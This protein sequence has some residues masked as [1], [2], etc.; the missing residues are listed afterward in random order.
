MAEENTE[1]LPYAQF[2]KQTFDQ[3][4]SV[5]G[6]DTGMFAKYLADTLGEEFDQPDMLTYDGLREGTAPI[7]NL[8][9]EGYQNLPP[10]K[11]KL[12]NDQII[13]LF[14][15]DMEGNPIKAGTFL[16]GVQ[17]E[18]IPTA[19]SIPT[20][21]GGYKAGSALVSMVPPT[22]PWT[23]G[24][25]FGVPLAFGTLASIGG[26]FMG[27]KIADE[28]MGEEPPM[29]PGQ[30]AA[31]EAGKTATS[32][33]G[34][35]T[36]P[37]AIPKQLNF[38]VE[39]A[40]QA[41]IKG[42]GDV[43]GPFETTGGLKAA[44]FLEG[45]VGKLGETAKA[46]PVPFLTIEALSGAGQT[47]GAY[48][49]ESGAPGQAIPRLTYETL[50][51][52]SV[53]VA[54]DLLTRKFVLAA[55]SIKG[56]YKAA[57]EGK[58]TEAFGYLK[59]ERKRQVINYV[60]DVIEEAGEDPNVII[61]RLGSNEFSDILVDDAGNPIELTA[62]LKSGSP[63]LLALEKSLEGVTSGVGRE[64]S[65]ANVSATRALR[66]TINALFALQNKE[67]TQAASE[68]AQAT[69]SA[70]MEKELG[71]AWGKVF[72]AF[73]AIGAPTARQAQL[74][75]NLES[76]LSN[77]LEAAR[78]NEKRLWKSVDTSFSI[79][80]F[81]DEEGQIT[82]TPQFISWMENNLPETEE[83]LDDMYPNIA[84]LIK[85]VNRKKREL[86][87][88][89]SDG[90]DGSAPTL[91]KELKKAY[92]QYQKYEDMFRGSDEERIL[93]SVSSRVD[94]IEDVNDKLSYLRQQAASLRERAKN[95]E[96]DDNN[97]IRKLATAYDRLA[98]LELIK[99]R[100]PQAALTQQVDL[101]D[102]SATEIYDMYSV[103]LA[104]GKEL[105][106][107]GKVNSSRLAYGFAQALMRDLDNFD[108]NDA[109]Y[110]IAR[111]YSRAL[112]D[113][114]TRSFVGD[115]LQETKTGAL[116]VAPEMIANDIFT[117]DAGYLRMKQLD[118]VGQFELTQALTNLSESAGTPDLRR[119][120]DR[121]I[122]YSVNEDT[123][124]VDTARLNKWLKNNRKGLSKYPG[125]LQNV[126]R[127]VETTTTI[128]GTTENILRNI[129]AQA[130]DPKTGEV[131]VAALRKWM[132]R[133]ENQDILSAMPA[134][135]ADLE[136][137]ESARILLDDQL[138]AQREDLK[139]LKAQV[140]FM[141]LLPGTTENPATAAAKALANQQKKPV[142]S[143]DNLLDV[144]KKAP[145]EW[146]TPD[147]VTHTKEDALKGLRA[148]FIEA[149]MVKSGGTS[150]TFSA[151][152][153][154][155]TI[156]APHRNSENKVSL[157][158]W[159][160]KNEVM[161]KVEMDRLRSL[162]TEL[163]KMESFVASG[164]VGL[165]E[166]S[167]TVGPMMD[168]YLRIVG[169]SVGSR[170]QRMIPGD[171]GAGQL[172]A[173]GAGSKAF[174]SAYSK[175]FADMPESMKMDVMTE[176]FKDP[177][178]LATMLSK[179]RS[180]RE[181]G[182]ISSR[183]IKLLTEKGLTKVT[184]GLSNVA[185]RSLPP[186]VRETE[187]VIVDQTPPIIEE[188][189]ANLMPQTV[190]PTNRTEVQPNRVTAPAPIVPTQNNASQPAA[191]SRYAALFPND[192]I[193][194]MIQPQQQGI[195]SL[196]G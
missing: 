121:A 102:L 133:P 154:F 135:K 7:F 68:I 51:G 132:A 53:P 104:K 130:F 172:V 29:L 13:E 90:G 11:R 17:R 176:M 111:S 188:E 34:W 153:F 180:E 98:N 63:A 194:G 26:Y 38:G 189:E 155:D 175:I 120:L 167:E 32:A 112:N 86:G 113:A 150:Q 39:A 173:A 142:A 192:P 137:V 82:D 20:F 28:I 127:A 146:T 18:V 139:D 119:T 148:S 122:N 61:Q 185:R 41:L 181:I 191:R 152:E 168:F 141:D 107:Q 156:F 52:I 114:F 101:K 84:P 117:A 19:T 164:D 160:L 47:G 22:T 126:E 163:V 166:L 187:E 190:L 45:T 162:A 96:F 92:D 123:G 128:R 89:P 93:E 4:M 157:S 37:F 83:A 193:S 183:L 125:V 159:M 2:D 36:L 43:A 158:D 73:E 31:Y 131:N 174:R 55:K 106:A 99:S 115:I 170:F 75:Q 195:G 143:W 80:S 24:I 74:G 35:L 116:K 65:S 14:S 95:K 49:A 118:Q 71:N 124:L 109:S 136:N 145:D 15:V 30:Q 21:M 54:A 94:N 100:E 87:L 91:S 177:D 67:S 1:N 50:G 23:A 178:L 81:I 40:K 5:Y 108:T 184:T 186:V 42:R 182:N 179:G 57:R 27:E 60:L 149:A 66:N 56:G 151:R 6:N 72:S 140:S 64:R 76:I 69:F 8:L 46:A 169:S 196:F 88:T 58:I 105:K 138:S 77:R 78:T 134:L 10:A 147:G 3:L 97:Q 9:G 12:S 103:A 165:E 171:T 62:A 129:R 44:E 110:N 48:V 85:F 70:D 144:V 79:D 59:D 161:S 16:E 33:A 25:R